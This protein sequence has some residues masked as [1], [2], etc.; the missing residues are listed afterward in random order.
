MAFFRNLSLRTRISLLTLV[1]VLSCLWS[2]TLYAS[3]TL[4]RDMQVLIEQQQTS[5]ARLIA[6][7]ID[8]EIRRRLDTLQ[9]IASFIPIGALQSPQAAQHF[10]QNMPSVEELFNGGVTLHNSRGITLGDTLP[11]TGRL[12]VDFSDQSALAQAL[13]QG[14]SSIGTPMVGKVLPTPQITMAVPVRD[15]GGI[16]IGALAGTIQLQLPSFLDPIRHGRYGLDGDYLLIDRVHRIFVVTANPPRGLQSLPPPGA[17]AKIDRFVAGHE[18]A[19]TFINSEGVEVQVAVHQVPSAQWLVAVSLPTASAFAPVRNMQTRVWLAAALA[20]LLALLLTRWMLTRQMAPAMRAIGQL[21]ERIAQVEHDSPAQPLPVS[22]PD[23]IG[24]LITAF[25]QLLLAQAQRKAMLSA[26]LNSSNVGIFSADHRGHITLV[27]DTVGRLFGHPNSRLIGMEY[28]SLVAPSER[29]A[30]QNHRASLS[31]AAELDVEVTRRLVRADGSEF[32][33]HVSVRRVQP[34]TEGVRGIVGVVTDISAQVDAHDYELFRRHT[35][36]LLA[37]TTPL[38]QTLEAIVKGVEELRPAALCSILL[39]QPDGK[40]LGQGIAPSLPAEY[41]AA[42]EGLEIGP[43]AGSCGAAAFTRE[44]VV[45]HDLQTHSNWA[46]YRKLTDR[47]GLRACWSQPLLGPDGEVLGTIALY[48]RMPQTPQA[49]DIALIEQ[50]AHLASLAITQHRHAQAVLD[51]EARYRAMIE[52]SPH[53]MAVHRQGIVIYVNPAT[54]RMMAADD[55]QALIGRPI[56]DFIHPDSRALVLARSQQV[57]QT[58]QD[59]PPVTEKYLRLDGNTIDVEAVATQ[60]V[61]DGTPAVL[62]SMQDIT[63]RNQN[64][65][66]LL[67]ASQVFDHAREGIMVTDTQ[68]H[69]VE[70]N[71]AFAR[72]TGYTREE[73]LGQTPRLLNS[74][75]QPRSYYATMWQTLRDSGNWTGEVWNRRKSGEIYAELQTISTVHD[76]Q[77]NPVNYV[78]LFSDIT[79]AKEHAQYIERIAHYDALTNLPNRVLLAD[80]LHQAMV[81]AQRRGLKTGVAFLDLDGFKGINDRHGHNVGDQLLVALAGQMRQALREGDTLARLG[82]DEFVAVL[83]DLGEAQA[84]VPLLS[85]LLQAAAQTIEIEEHALQVTASLGVTFFPQLEEVDADQLLRQADQAMYQAKLAGKNRYHVFD[86]EQDRHVRG[87]HESLDRIRI[88]LGNQEFTLHYQPKVNMRSGE[89]LGAEALIRWQH[90]EQGLLAPAASLPIV[91]DHPLAV[92]IGEWV[93][94]DA[95]R[96][97][98]HWVQQGLHLSI[99]VNIGARQLQQPDFVANLE[100][101]LARHPT[102]RPHQLELE[103]LETSALEDLAHVSN[104]IEACSAMGVS[105]ALDDFGTGYSSLS[106]LKRLPASLLKIDQSFVRDMLDDP[107]DLAILD[108]VIGLANAFRRDVIAEGVETMEHGTLLLQLGCELGQGYGIAHPMP[109]EQ[110]PVWAT[111]WVP[112]TVWQ[113]AQRVHREDMALL[114]VSIEHRAWCA[115]IEAF[116]QGR[117]PA[118]S[119]AQLRDCRFERWLNREGSQRYGAHPTFTLLDTL[120]ERLHELARKLH[121]LAEKGHR[122][123]AVAGLTE[124]HALQENLAVQIQRL[125]ATAHA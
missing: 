105:F 27:N 123:Q 44:R 2:L 55:V 26:V 47:F 69:I 125:L 52:W 101:L 10:L 93:L 57:A 112:Q 113:S 56:L 66:R 98:E 20:S 46:A 19:A 124:L 83:V 107:D 78:S 114:Y 94:Q 89:V 60:I 54:V 58:G 61:F 103:V 5:T 121:A 53:P 70:V 49:P 62:V 24:H 71:A 8:R 104:V 6:E 59:L 67:L 99:S 29:E 28:M 87:H 7:D 25:N 110:F 14:V 116:I 90:P 73:V 108:G 120:H 75:R 31:T 97:L 50:A 80:R 85:R 118:L 23:E 41:N 38:P 64:Q 1:I 15:A 40:H 74:G 95:V 30:A 32:W 81:Q 17:N 82:G 86:A 16:V 76:D 122:E 111:Q 115:E 43:F 92:E 119:A 79:T 48:H 12:G 21:T 106:Y 109:A 11:G 68:G 91:E 42:V 3:A 4:H 22:R 13:D 96:Q 51:S 45:A 84:C 102:V 72:I 100:A 18:G 36:E 9:A 37:H 117:G 88:A 34:G 39:R 77:G 65:R 63:R 35:L 33:G